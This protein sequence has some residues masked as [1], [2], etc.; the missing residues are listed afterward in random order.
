MRAIVASPTSTA[1][2]TCF[3][4]LPTRWT[5]GGLEPSPDELD[6]I[7]CELVD[8]QDILHSPDEPLENFELIDTPVEPQARQRVT[9]AAAP[10]Q[11][12][13]AGTD[14]QSED[15]DAEDVRPQRLRIQDGATRGPQRGKGSRQTLFWKLATQPEHGVTTGAVQDH[16][17]AGDVSLPTW[18]W[19]AVASVE[20]VETRTALLLAAE[21]VL[22]DAALPIG[23]VKRRLEE[24][25]RTAKRAAKLEILEAM[26]A[27]EGDDW[28]G[29]DE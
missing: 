8:I 16:S 18:L 20:S 28:E 12:A 14:Y 15:T 13:P 2:L 6:F 1:W 3:L 4:A 23:Q 7:S 19:S 21:D 27:E 22:D 5:T 24:I 10:W 26:R 17:V 25:A 9:A 29:A 11:D